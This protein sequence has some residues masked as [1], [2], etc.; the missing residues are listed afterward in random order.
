M[1]NFHATV[2]GKRFF[3]G[4]F[5]LLVVALETIAKSL[6]KEV[7]TPKPPAA[8]SEKLDVEAVREWLRRDTPV[9]EGHT[10][11]LETT[12]LEDLSEQLSILQVQRLTISR[13]PVGFWEAEV[14]WQKEILKCR[15]L[16]MHDALDHVLL[17]VR[18]ER[19]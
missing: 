17:A 1:I 7:E 16:T 2:M 19:M 18:S 11:M 12:K 3:D 4:M 15:A 13:D 10:W 9:D 8:A 5:P 14:L 6:S